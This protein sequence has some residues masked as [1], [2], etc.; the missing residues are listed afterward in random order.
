MFGERKKTQDK[1][2]PKGF[3]STL[4]GWKRSCKANA[5]IDDNSYVEM[6][7]Q[8]QI[9]LV[10]GL[11]KLYTLVISRASWKGPLLKESMNG[12]P[13][14]HDILERLG[15][16]K[17]DLDVGSDV[18][19]EDLDLLRQKLAT[20]TDSVMQSHRGSLSSEYHGQFSAM[21]VASPRSY[22]GDSFNPLRQFPPTPPIQSPN[23]EIP[24]SQSPA[25]CQKQ[26]DREAGLDPFIL[27]SPPPRIGHQQSAMYD[28]CLDFLN[29]DMSNPMQGSA[30]PCLSISPW[31]H[32]DLSAFELKADDT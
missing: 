24:S 30:S 3:V 32:D 16:L 10:T 28:G 20:G 12:H 25:D 4:P 27:Q 17:F 2:Y 13:L 18:F 19:E 8:Q 29:F 31:L 11:Q 26:C 15:V 14:T 9:Q 7:E 22:F 5:V 21:E 23:E 6:L 1:I